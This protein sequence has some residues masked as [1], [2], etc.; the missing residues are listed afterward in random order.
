MCIKACLVPCNYNVIGFEVLAVV[1]VSGNDA[2]FKNVLPVSIFAKL[3]SSWF[4]Q[5][6]TSLSF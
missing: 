3:G 1:T 2:K 6:D 4:L 5:F